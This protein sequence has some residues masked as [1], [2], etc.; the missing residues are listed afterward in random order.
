[1]SKNAANF[2]FWAK[3]I[4]SDIK[5]K[6][7]HHYPGGGVNTA[8]LR[9]APQHHLTQVEK[10]EFTALQAVCRIEE[11]KND[12]QKLRK[13]MK[14]H[15]FW[16]AG[17]SILRAESFSCSLDVHHGGLGMN[18]LY[19]LIKKNKNFFQ[20]VIFY[21]FCSSNPLIWIRIDQICWIRIR[22]ETNADSHH[23]KKEL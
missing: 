18:V 7:W 8:S 3:L 21:N 13:V 10:R 9:P 12:P 15:V 5:V 16:S 19:F 22:I 4:K 6:R 23:R 14:F 17:C 1:M 20:L 2:F 11:G